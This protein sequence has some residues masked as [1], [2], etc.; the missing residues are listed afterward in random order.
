MPFPQHALIASALGQI[1]DSCRWRK[2]LENLSNKY[3]NQVASR[4]QAEQACLC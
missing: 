4:G 2:C 1:A 3:G